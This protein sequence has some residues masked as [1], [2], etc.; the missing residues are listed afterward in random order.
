MRRGSLYSNKPERD[1]NE[2][3]KEMIFFWNGLTAYAAR[4]LERLRQKY[5][6]V[7]VVAY[8]SSF[9]YAGVE[10]MFG[11][12]ID[13][14]DRD[15][16][17]RLA[18]ICGA[19]YAIVFT[20]GWNEPVFERFSREAKENG[21]PVVCC[22]DNNFSFGPKTLLQ[23]LAF[24]TFRRGKYDGFFVPGASGVKLLRFFGVDANRITTGYYSGDDQLFSCGDRMGMRKNKILA[25]GQLV[26]RKNVLN[27]AKAFLSVCKEHGNWELEF[28]GRGEL[29]DR[30]PRHP[31]ITVTDF[32]Q[33]DKL[34]EKYR[35]SKVFILASH[36]DH[37][38]VAVHEGALC[39]CALLISERVGAGEDFVTCKNGMR[40]NPCNVDSI[41]KAMKTI[42]EWKETDFDTAMKESIALSHKFGRET[43]ANNALGMA[44]R[45]GAT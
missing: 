32:L 40:F 44:K 11:G 20:S 3:S 21:K 8:R 27:V 6:R 43:F 10:T 19:D 2:T 28:C 9:P 17:R 26:H 22:L 1:M 15:E 16:T 42:M 25:V 24:R 18:D 41:A 36:S 34:A 14:I 7:R 45:L 38:G 12:K 4:S 30:I 35:E 5:G 37:W 31:Q 23:A 29:R 33:P 39:G 13:W